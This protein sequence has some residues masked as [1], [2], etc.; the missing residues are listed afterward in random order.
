MLDKLFVARSRVVGG[1]TRGMIKKH[2]KVG[3]TIDKLQLD[4][5]MYYTAI[6]DRKTP[7]PARTLRNTIITT[8]FDSLFHTQRIKY[9]LQNKINDSNS[10]PASGFWSG[11]VVDS[12]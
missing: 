12:D 10:S 7:M 2:D 4:L 1:S 8:L 5:A 3:L 11:P 9:D 6:R